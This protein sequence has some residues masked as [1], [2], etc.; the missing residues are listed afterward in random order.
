MP[1]EILFKNPP[2]RDTRV[3]A[4]DLRC[5]PHPTGLCQEQEDCGLRG[6]RLEQAGCQKLDRIVQL[7]S[8]IKRLVF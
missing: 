3:A 2:L 4:L 1:T 7:L 6:I 5:S 8:L